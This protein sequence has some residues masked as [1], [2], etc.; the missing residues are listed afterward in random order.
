MY[1]IKIVFIINIKLNI[2]S[3][4]KVGPKNKCKNYNFDYYYK[5]TSI[6]NIIS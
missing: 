1:F 3:D 5:C 6:M 2:Y 4:I